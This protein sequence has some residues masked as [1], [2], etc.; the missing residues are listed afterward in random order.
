MAEGR[1]R[2][3][4]TLLCSGLCFCAIN[5]KSPHKHYKNARWRAICMAQCV[6]NKCA[7]A[8]DFIACVRA[9]NCNTYCI[10]QKKIYNF[11]AVNNKYYQKYEKNVFYL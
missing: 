3:A 6:S 5:V 2:S 11:V 10:Y 4:L 8:R 1:C 9:N 7:R